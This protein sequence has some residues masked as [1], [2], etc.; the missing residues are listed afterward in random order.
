MLQ[1]RLI[2]C[3]NL[4]IICHT[5][6]PLVLNKFTQIFMMEAKRGT[7]GKRMLISRQKYIIYNIKKIIPSIFQHVHYNLIFKTGHIT[8]T[9]YFL[10]QIL[11]TFSHSKWKIFFIFSRSFSEQ[12]KLKLFTTKTHIFHFKNPHILQYYAE[13]SL[14]KLP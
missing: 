4:W 2:R 7:V 9:S 3:R 10:I 6:N 12:K 11:I 8:F 13:N 14:E 5:F 1:K